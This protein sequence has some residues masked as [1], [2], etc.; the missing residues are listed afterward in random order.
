M[1]NG[2]IRGRKRY[3]MI[4]DVKIYGSNADLRGRQKIG[5]TGECWVCSERYAISQNTM[6]TENIWAKRD[7]VTGEWRKLHNAELH[8]LYS[9][10]DIIRNIKSRHLR[11]AGHAAHMGESRNAYRVLVGRPAGKRPLGRPRCRWEDNIKMD[12]RDVG[13]DGKEWINLAQDRDQ[14]RAYVRAAMNLRD[15]DNDNTDDN[16]NNK[17]DNIGY[18]DHYNISRGQPIRGGPPAWGLGEGLT[19]HHRKK[20]LVTNPYNK[21][22]NRT[23]SLARPQQRN[24]VLR[25][26]TWNVTSLYRTGGVTL[27]AKELARYRIDFVGVQEVRSADCNSDHY[28]V[29]G[30]LRERLSVAKRV[31]QQVNITKFNILKLKDEEAKQNYQVEISNRFATSE[32]SDEVEKELDV[33]SVWENIKDSIKIAADQ[34]IDYYETKKKKP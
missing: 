31:E 28:L 15:D 5:K 16:A 20:Q 18:V 7:E 3:Q 23:D 2:R 6:Y 10:P 24:K 27:V 34:S 25:F 1:V 19:T 11:W 32:S 4:D 33:N 9:S 17:S 30:E 8:A 22:R 21:P 12:L 13:Y 29:I 14:W 26:G